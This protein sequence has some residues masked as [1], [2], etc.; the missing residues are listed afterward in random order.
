MRAEGLITTAPPS[1]ADLS[2]KSNLTRRAWHAKTCGRVSQ[3]TNQVALHVVISLS[4]VNNRLRL[5]DDGTLI[6]RI[7]LGIDL[8]PIY[9]LPPPP[10]HFL[11]F[12]LPVFVPPTLSA[13]PPSLLPLPP[14]YPPSISSLSSGPKPVVT[15][16]SSH[17]VSSKFSLYIQFG[18]DGQ[19]TV[20]TYMQ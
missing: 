2:V 20:R 3:P 16:G 5:L 19:Y 11:P 8:S 15:G 14:S 17:A 12:S 18:D 7:S 4:E 1:S 10:F 6:C 9:L 13:S